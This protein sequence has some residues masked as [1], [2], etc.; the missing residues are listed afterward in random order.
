MKRNILLI[1]TNAVHTA[2]YCKTFLKRQK[3]RDMGKGQQEKKDLD[4]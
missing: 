4:V 3:K 2:I 1:K